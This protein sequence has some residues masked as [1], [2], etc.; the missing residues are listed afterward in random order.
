MP[1]DSLR[2]LLFAVENFVK[3]AETIPR[4]DLLAPKLP[5]VGKDSMEKYHIKLT[6]AEAATLA[7]IDFRTSHQSHDES[8]AAHKANEEPILA[9]LAS[10]SERKALPQER[11][12]F[13]NSPRYQLGRI[14]ASH[15]GLFERNGCTGV[16]IY[17]HAHFIP[18]LRYF[19]FG[20][21]LPHEVIS[22]FESRVGNPQWISSSD[23]VPI[24]K[25]ARE[26]TRRHQLDARDASMEFFK[27]CLDMGL[28][29]GTAQSVSHAVKQIR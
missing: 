2:Q 9:L 24:G 8:H 13:W 29:V 26:L 12:N 7:R 3:A 17:T 14:K 20:A 25:F 23:V 16:D 11:Q 27:L 28:G 5:M 15:K 18:Y 21:D 6:D 19:L 10:L 22:A 1:R 4:P